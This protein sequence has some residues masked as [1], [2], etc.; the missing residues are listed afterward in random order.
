MKENSATQQVKHEV[1]ISREVIFVQLPLKRTSFHAKIKR[2]SHYF[3]K[4]WY[5]LAEKTFSKAKKPANTGGIPFV[6]I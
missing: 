4:I 2:L 3:F 1:Q 6:K 5:R